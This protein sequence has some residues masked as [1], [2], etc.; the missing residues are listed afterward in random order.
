MD[1]DISLAYWLLRLSQYSRIASM[2]WSNDDLIIRHSKIEREMALPEVSYLGYL[3]VYR[4]S[5][6]WRDMQREFARNDSKEG[7]YI[8]AVGESWSVCPP[9][10]GATSTE[11]LAR[12]EALPTF[13]V[14]RKEKNKKKKKRKKDRGKGKAILKTLWSVSFA[15]IREPM[16]K[17]TGVIFPGCD[18][19]E[20]ANYTIYSL[21]KRPIMDKRERAS[22]ERQ[23]S[24]IADGERNSSHFLSLSLSLS[25]SLS[26][27]GELVLNPTAHGTRAS[28]SLLPGRSSATRQTRR[29]EYVVPGRRERKKGTKGSH[30][31]RHA[32]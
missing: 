6:S 27:D 5:L 13:L 12:N 28:L 17:A 31:V 25:F 2:P 22:P 15:D 32:G 26:I 29:L 11:F 24:F 8:F 7:M 1:N 10:G 18:F 3:F 21:Q 20:S 19:E 4:T 16:K 14:P 9:E 23:R 30:A